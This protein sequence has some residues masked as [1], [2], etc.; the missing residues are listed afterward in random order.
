MRPGVWAGS[1]AA[2]ARGSSDGA[3]GAGAVEEEVYGE[4]GQQVGRLAGAG[5]GS[6]WMQ[7]SGEN[8]VSEDLSFEIDSDSHWMSVLA[9]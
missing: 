8:G 6:G 2:V 3:G 7:I 9:F 4:A 1:V 5:G